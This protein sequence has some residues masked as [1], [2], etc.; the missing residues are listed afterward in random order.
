MELFLKII[1]PASILLSLAL[2]FGVLIAVLGKKLAVSVDPRE[3]EVQAL[4][5]GANCG[6]CGYPG[7]AGFAKALVAGT[8]NLSDCSATAQSRKAQIAAVLGI[9]AGSSV[10]YVI[11]CCGGN[12]AKDKYEYMGFGDCRSMELLAG[13]RKECPRGCLG[14][15]SCTTACGFNAVVAA[16]EKEGYA[17]IDRQRCVSCGACARAC[18]KELIKR[19]PVDAKYYVACSNHERGK[20][21]RAACKKGCLACGACARKC[22]AGAIS[23]VDNLAVID[24]EKCTSCGACAAACPANCILEVK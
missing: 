15:G 9:E 19:I 18:P 1:I 21:V 6:G 7:C 13:G 12:E 10:R 20:E 2:V 8:A 16:G 4:L 14:M 11:C 5:S 3:E 23:I 24:Y 22:S 17:I